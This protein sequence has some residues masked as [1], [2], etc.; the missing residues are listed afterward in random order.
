[1]L[2]E[3]NTLWMQVLRARYG[4][5]EDWVEGFDEGTSFRNC[6][7]WWRNITT[8]D[9]FNSSLDWFQ[10]GI[11]RILGR[12]DGTRFWEDTWVGNGSLKG[13]F[14]TLLYSISTQK[15]LKIAN[16][17]VGRT[18][19]GLAFGL[20]QLSSRFCMMISTG[21]NTCEWNT[22]ALSEWNTWEFG[23]V[24]VSSELDEW[25]TSKCRV[26]WGFEWISCEC[27]ME[28][29]TRIKSLVLLFCWISALDCLVF[30][31]TVVSLDAAI[32]RFGVTVTVLLYGHNIV[33][34]G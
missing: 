17:G 8:L 26:E 34:Y 21:L 30:G 1:M 16:F 4:L 13:L 23:V 15:D 11:K 28:W 6:S 3:P 33:V 32:F 14:P 5:L 25:N 22:W 20:E 12:G 7:S 19:N 2:K 29:Y 18:Q 24:W 27:S 31:C 10:E 9:R